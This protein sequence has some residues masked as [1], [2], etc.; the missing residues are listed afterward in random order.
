LLSRR[1]DALPPSSGWKNKLSKHRVCQKKRNVHGT[2]KDK[3][4]VGK[5]KKIKILEKRE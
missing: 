4:D 3:N 2:G 1:T 5:K